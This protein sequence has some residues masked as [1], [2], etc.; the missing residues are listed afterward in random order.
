MRKADADAAP[1][2]V[3]CDIIIAADFATSDPRIPFSI[4]IMHARPLILSEFFPTVFIE[5]L[6]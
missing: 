5:Y 2:A 1:I 3:V 6:Q 4:C